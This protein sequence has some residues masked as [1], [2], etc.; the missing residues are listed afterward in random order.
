MCEKSAR[1]SVRTARKHAVIATTTP[2]VLLAA[3]APTGKIV[4]AR[5]VALALARTGSNAHANDRMK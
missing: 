5:R 2:P 4:L 3:A 1:S